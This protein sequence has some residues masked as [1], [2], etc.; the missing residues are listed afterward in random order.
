MRATWND[1][2]ERLDMMMRDARRLPR[3]VP[4][5]RLKIE[6]SVINALADRLIRLLRR[7]DP[8]CDNVKLGRFSVA[9]AGIS[10][11]GRAW[12]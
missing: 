2:L 10:G 4:D 6:T 5:T 11:L 8:L 1:M 9:C 7:R 3:C 12:L